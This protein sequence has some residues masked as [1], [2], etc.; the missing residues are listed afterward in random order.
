MVPKLAPKWP[1][2][3]KI[4]IFSLCL[5]DLW[6]KIGQKIFLKKFYQNLWHKNPET[7]YD[8]EKNR[9]GEKNCEM[10]PKLAPKWPKWPKIAIFSLCLADLWGINLTKYFSENILSKLMA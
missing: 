3:P 8:F 1:K 4:A 2:W 7:E 5:A 9:L 10:M 6:R